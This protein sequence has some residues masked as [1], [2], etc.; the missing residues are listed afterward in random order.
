MKKKWR[1]KDKEHKEKNE[2]INN[3]EEKSKKK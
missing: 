3:H 1:S 2:E